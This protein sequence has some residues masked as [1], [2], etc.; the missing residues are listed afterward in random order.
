MYYNYEDKNPKSQS[1]K[2]KLIPL[3]CRTSK[4]TTLNQTFCVGLSVSSNSSFTAPSVGF[5]FMEKPSFFCIFTSFAWLG[6]FTAGFSSVPKTVWSHN[7][8]HRSKLRFV[9][10]TVKTY[11]QKLVQSCILL[12]V[13]A[14]SYPTIPQIYSLTLLNTDYILSLSV[15]HQKA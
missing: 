10:W 9:H 13:Q 6:F 11:S 7:F 4:L 14:K 5:L 3:H 15:W 8:N 2:A 1:C 12:N